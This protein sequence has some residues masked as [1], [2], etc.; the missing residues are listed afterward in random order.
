MF[1]PQALQR[2]TGAKAEEARLE[3]FDQ[4]AWESVIHRLAYVSGHVDDPVT[5]QNLFRCLTRLKPDTGGNVL[6][7][8]ARAPQFFV[9]VVQR[10]GEAGLAREGEGA[11]RRIVTEKPFGRDLASAKVLNQTSLQVFREDQIFRMDHF[12]GKDTVQ[13]ILAFRFNLSRLTSVRRRLEKARLRVAL[14]F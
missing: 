7:Y 8:L 11:W 10:I 14:E 9:S 2:Y 3:A 4:N 13:N 5:F 12:L 6:F 1:F